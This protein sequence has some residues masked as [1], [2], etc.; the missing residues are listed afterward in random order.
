MQAYKI[1]AK[2]TRTGVRIQRQFLSGNVITDLESAWRE[3]QQ[4]AEAQSSRDRE[5]WVADVAQYVVGS[6][7]GSQ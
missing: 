3:A 5:A 1:M 7:P 2:N 6:K 4:L